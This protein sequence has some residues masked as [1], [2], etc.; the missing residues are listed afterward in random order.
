MPS[1][2]KIRLIENDVQ[3]HYSIH[4]VFIG[5][6]ADLLGNDLALHFGNAL[7]GMADSIERTYG[8]VSLYRFFSVGLKPS[9]GLTLFS[10]PATGSLPDSFTYGWHKKTACCNLLGGKRSFEQATGGK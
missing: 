3:S 6:E 2:L 5:I 10:S 8:F 7:L 1:D 9:D 4:K